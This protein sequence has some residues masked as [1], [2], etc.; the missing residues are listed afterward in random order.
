[1]GYFKNYVA[2]TVILSNNTTRY[3]IL[4]LTFKVWLINDK[5]LTLENFGL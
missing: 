1:M 2:R 3:L 4:G 5:K